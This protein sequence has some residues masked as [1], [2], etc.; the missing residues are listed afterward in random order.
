LRVLLFA[1]R[2]EPVPLNDEDDGVRDPEGLVPLGLV[3]L[4]DELRPNAY[5]TLTAFA[6][7]GVD[8]K[9][10]SG[11]NPETVK[12]LAVQAG[13][14]P[15]ARLISGPE[16]DQLGDGQLD[17]A[18]LENG[19]F[20]RI[21][22]EQKE[23]LVEA[24]HAQ[25]RYVAMTGDGV[26]DV[27]SLKK[28]NL[29][30][31]MQS[32]SQATR[33]VADIVLTNDSFAVLPHA[34][35][36]GRR[37][38]AGMQNVLKLFLSRTF[39][40]ALVIIAIGILGAFPFSP[41]Q[42]ALLSFLTAGIPA[43]ALAAWARPARAQHGSTLARLASFS[44]PAGIGVALVGLILF[45]LY[46]VP[47]FDLATENGVT[48]KEINTAIKD[49]VPRAQ[50]VLTYFLI[51]CGLLLVVFVEPPNRFWAVGGETSGDRRPAWLT[52]VLLAA[53]LVIAFVPAFSQIF[54]LRPISL[55]DILAV[56]AAAA[57]WVLLVRVAWKRRLLER[58]LGADLPR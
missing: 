9:I 1:F 57:V 42:S 39:F 46:C 26:N 28:A 47:I 19:V 38:I 31:A 58:F 4:T 10:I 20:G 8:L 14:D 21:T 34:I 52:L 43:V 54:D 37:I 49:T 23:A 50:T 22:P 24:L 16:L 40:V 51:V 15:E 48:I 55:L 30:I 33:G 29:G 53:L 41:R 32:G 11:D 27:L 7:A 6:E 45:T 3:G 2:P 35:T 56:L 5:E 25:G 44:V 36:E 17:V 12:A 13:F 18:A